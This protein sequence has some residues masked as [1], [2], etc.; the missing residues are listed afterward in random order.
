MKIKIIISND[1]IITYL[2]LLTDSDPTIFNAIV[3]DIKQKKVINAKI[4]AIEKN[5]T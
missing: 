2:I 5:E 1:D 3:M 4:N